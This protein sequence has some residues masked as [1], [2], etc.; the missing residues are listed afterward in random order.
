VTE[1]DAEPPP[2]TYEHV[3][4][5]PH[6][7]IALA[8][9]RHMAPAEAREIVERLTRDLDACAAELEAQGTLVDGAAR[10]VAV[11]GPRGT[12]EGLNVRLAPGGAVAQNA[13]LC[14]V[15]PLRAIT[16][17]KG[18]GGGAPAIAIEATWGPRG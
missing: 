8:E 3:A 17:P 7:I 2:D 13:L 16:F 5:A 9:A 18:T 10:I 15:A 1:A 6:G 11:S 14:L 12:V 4:R